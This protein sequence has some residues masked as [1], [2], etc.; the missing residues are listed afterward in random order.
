MAWIKTVSPEEAEGRLQK[1]YERLAGANRQ[2]DHIMQ[3]HSLRPH[4]LEG[5]MALYKNVL[6]HSA[7]TLPKWFLEAVG[8]YV[9]Y[10]NGCDYCVRHH[11]TG[12]RR[13]IDGEERAEAIRRALV[14]DEP[15]R[16]FAQAELALIRYARVL[17]LEPGRIS[18]STL[19]DL[20]AAGAMDGEILEVNQVVSY[21]CYANRTV[22]GLG[23]SIEGESL[24]LSPNNSGDSGDWRHR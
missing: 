14:A 6:H 3:I 17:A 12:M 8:V 22:L 9:S 19:D 10:L 24:G 23:V 21:F 20:R 7:N 16:V 11:F 1:L 13:E 4:T 15:E 18:R 5:H 2:V